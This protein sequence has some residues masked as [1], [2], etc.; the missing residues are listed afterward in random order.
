MHETT[1]GTIVYLN[2]LHAALAGQSLHSV[3]ANNNMHVHILFVSLMQKY[4]CLYDKVSWAAPLK[5]QLGTFVW[6]HDW[7]WSNAAINVQ[8]LSAN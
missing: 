4:M 2:A 3:M 7:H 1:E 8:D 6:P 5:I